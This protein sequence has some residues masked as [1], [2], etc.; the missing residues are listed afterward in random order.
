VKKQVWQKE[1]C[2]EASYFFDS[3]EK[4]KQK[5]PIRSEKNPTE[6][7]KAS[8]SSKKIGFQQK[9]TFST[10]REKMIQQ[11]GPKQGKN[12]LRQE[13]NCSRENPALQPKKSPQQKKYIS[14]AGKNSSPGGPRRSGSEGG[15]HEGRQ[16]ETGLED[17]A[18][19]AAKAAIMQQG[20]RRT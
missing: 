18:A 14:A 11:Q 7:E 1:H 4:R 2:F 9:N 10:Q 5:I 8:R 12:R 17:K 16:A 6:Q 20:R 13:K 3:M 19:A 15:S